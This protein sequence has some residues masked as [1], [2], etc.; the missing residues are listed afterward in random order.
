MFALNFAVHFSVSLIC[1]CQESAR[2][3]TSTMSMRFVW[4]MSFC[5]KIF[6]LVTIPFVWQLF[7]HYVKSNKSYLAQHLFL[8]AFVKPLNMHLCAL[9]N[10][11]F[12]VFFM[13]KKSLCGLEMA[14]HPFIP[15]L[16]LGACEYAN[17]GKWICK[18]YE[19]VCLKY[20]LVCS[21]L[22]EQFVLLHQKKHTICYPFESELC[23]SS[24]SHWLVNLVTAYVNDSPCKWSELFP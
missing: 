7:S 18:S 8:C 9:A 11:I 2:D 17:F 20:V 6:T 21:N 24:Q 22:K 19:P 13:K 14:R 12:R 15:H 5:V 10:Y 23:F 3:R 1:G 4:L 16:G